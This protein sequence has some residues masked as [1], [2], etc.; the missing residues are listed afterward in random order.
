MKRYGFLVVAAMAV[1]GGCTTDSQS[2]QRTA[3][4][5]AIMDDSVPQVARDACLREVGRTTNNPDLTILEML[6]SE[7]NSQV[8]IGVGPNRAPWQCTVSNRG[9][10]A[11]VTSLT[12]EGAL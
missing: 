1:S 11:N 8:K 4:A 2:P 5:P 12:D 7:A 10:V 3:A 6:Y 9:E